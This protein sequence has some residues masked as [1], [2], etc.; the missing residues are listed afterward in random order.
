MLQKVLF[1]ERPINQML[2][3]SK[4]TVYVT[5]YHQSLKNRN[6]KDTLHSKTEHNFIFPGFKDSR[7]TFGV[8]LCAW[9]KTVHTCV[10]MLL[11]LLVAKLTI[12][13]YVMVSS[14]FR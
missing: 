10:E 11:L 6:A 13:L 12:Q 8:L 14:W 9:L 3:D 2:C 4:G 5:Q 7:G 1:N